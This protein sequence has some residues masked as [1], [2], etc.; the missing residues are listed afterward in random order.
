M[1]R[2]SLF[3]LGTQSRAASVTAAMSQNLYYEQRPA[4]EKA[5]IVGYADP[6]LDLFAQAGDTK[7]RG[8][9]PVEETVFFY[10]VH[11]GVFYEVNNAGVLTSR[12]TL[13]STSG[14][15]SMT[16]NGTVVLVVDG[17]DAYT[18]TIATTTFA[19]VTDVELIASPKTCTWIDQYFVV[20]NGDEFQISTNGTTWP[21]LDKAVPESSPDGM[22]L[23]FSDH[24]QLLPF[25]DISTE[26]WEDTGATDFPFAP[27]KSST[28]EWGLASPWSLVKFNDSVAGLVKN[29][30]GQVSVAVFAGTIPKKVSTPDIDSIINGY[31][32]VNDAT[33]ISYML[34]GHPMYQ[35]NFP[36][37]GYSWR[38]DGLTGHWSSRKSYGSTRQRCEIGINYLNRTVFS[39]AANGNLY[40]LNQETYTENGDPIEVELVDDTLATQNLER[41]NIDRLRIDMETGVG[42][43]T[44]QGSNPQIMLQV[45]RDGGHAWGT[46]MWQTMGKIGAYRTRVEWRRLGF[47]DQVTFKLRITD[48]VKRVLVSA[49][50]NPPD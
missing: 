11:R 24:G 1:A 15:V 2:I 14:R 6:G 45:S 50:I 32:A 46:E 43:A 4:G 37:A 28:A 26:F 41:F 33:A 38:Y 35:I 16:H 40:T 18:Y 44:G 17:T 48:P 34:N 13:N 5:Q 39:D 25:G 19:Q 9:I 8:L 12:G 10:G 31:S 30:M 7:W 29:R 22:V 47:S 20:E 36:T 42:L 21:A 3:G 23:I 49:M 27:I